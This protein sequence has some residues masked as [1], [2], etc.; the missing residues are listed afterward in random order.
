MTEEVMIGI[1][2]VLS[3]VI[4]RSRV[5]PRLCVGKRTCCVRLVLFRLPE[6]WLDY[7]SSR[8][9]RSQFRP[10]RSTVA[11]IRHF[12]NEKNK[13]KKRQPFASM[14]CYVSGFFS[15]MIVEYFAALAYKCLTILEIFKTKTR[16][17]SILNIGVKKSMS[18]RPTD[19]ACKN[20]SRKIRHFSLN[21]RSLNFSSLM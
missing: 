19:G 9:S 20:G 8:S 11:R 4:Q 5:R 14:A 7:G 1:R 3:F 12:Y 10:S 15:L 2:V 16:R 18:V 17:S 13:R 6:N 21:S